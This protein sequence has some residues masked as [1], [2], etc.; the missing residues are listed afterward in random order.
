[1]Y[2]YTEFA[3]REGWAVT[4]R[5]SGSAARGFATLEEDWFEGIRFRG[6]R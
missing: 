5:D 4:I 3:M 2:G 6:N 1:M